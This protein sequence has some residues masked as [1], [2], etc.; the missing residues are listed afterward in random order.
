MNRPKRLHDEDGTSFV[1]HP[2][3][4]D[5]FCSLPANIVEI[6]RNVKKN[7]MQEAQFVMMKEP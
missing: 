1:C 2:L 4:N 7:L 6:G 3:A 5:G